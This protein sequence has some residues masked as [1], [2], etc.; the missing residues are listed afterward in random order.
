MPQVDLFGQRFHLL[1]ELHEYTTN[2]ARPNHGVANMWFSVV[3]VFLAMWVIEWI[4]RALWSTVDSKFIKTDHARIILG[5]H[6][7]DVVSMIAISYAG[8][9]GLQEFGGW[10]AYKELIKDGKILQFGIERVYSFSP[11]CQRLCVLQLAYEAKNFCD[12]VI[13][14]D[15]AIFLAHHFLA[16]CAAFC[17]STPFMHV[18]AAFYLGY[19]EISTIV[20]CVIVLFDKDHGL[21]GLADAYPMTMTITGVLFG[22]LFTLYRIVLWPYVSYYFWQDMYQIHIDNTCHSLPQFYFVVLINFC[23]TGVQFYWFKEIIDQAVSLIKTGKPLAI[24]RG[25]A[26]EIKAKGGNGNGS[27]RTPAH[28]QPQPTPTRR[29]PSRSAKKD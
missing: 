15:G 28:K 29:Q 23:L 24:D 25:D 19:S 10:G 20:L 13:H 7:N 9:E 8:W 18:Y 6:T 2:N 11:A 4:A 3:T 16:G 17:A 5:R 21:P 14:N 12:S 26:T 22:A 1:L 27:P